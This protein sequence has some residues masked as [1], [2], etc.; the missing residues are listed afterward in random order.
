[1]PAY[2]FQRRFAPDVRSGRKRQ[3]IRKLRK[4]GRVPKVGEKFVGY[5]GMRTK[6]CEKLCEGTIAQVRHIHFCGRGTVYVDGCCATSHSMRELASADGFAH[7]V[8]MLDFFEQTHGFP[9]E[10]HIINWDPDRVVR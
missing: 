3:T 9:F 1:M 2:N 5:T 4:D 8:Y 10:G 7:L 6:V